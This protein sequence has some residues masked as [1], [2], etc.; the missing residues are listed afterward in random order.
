M[1]TETQC[2]NAK[3]KEKPYKLAD[4]K[5]L[6][7]EVKTNGVTPYKAADISRNGV[8]SRLMAGS[9]GHVQASAKSRWPFLVTVTNSRSPARIWWRLQ[10]G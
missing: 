4:G 2:R 10:R 8:A 3:P 1:L 6:Y 7:L 5:G 9:G